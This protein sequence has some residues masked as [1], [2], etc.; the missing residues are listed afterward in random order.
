MCR[1]K[2]SYNTNLIVFIDFKEDIS[3]ITDLSDM[4]VA[5]SIGK[6]KVPVEID[7]KAIVD[8]LLSS[9]NLIAFL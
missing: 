2:V 4:W 1:V 6:A 7:V 5:S 3:S 8:R 9:A